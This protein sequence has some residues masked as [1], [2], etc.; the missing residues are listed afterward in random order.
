[1]SQLVHE[2][3][4]PIQSGDAR[5]LAEEV[6]ERLRSLVE[7]G[8]LRDGDR[9]P[10]T[11]DLATRLGV[12]RGV[13]LKAVRMLEREGTLRARV[14]SGIT[15]VA[16]ERAPASTWEPVFSS[17]IRRVSESPGY[18]TASAWPESPSFSWAYCRTVSSCRYRVRP[19]VLSVTTKDLSTSNVSRSR[20]W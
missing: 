13:L 14:G 15:V 5:P 6:A 18:Y 11:R 17:A 19:L 7:Q 9:L 8:V 4:A 10:P 16:P 12:N 3:Y 20:T 1:M 2:L